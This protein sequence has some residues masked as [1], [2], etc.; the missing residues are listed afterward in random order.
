MDSCTV[1]A[2][3]L[4]TSSATDRRDRVGVKLM[5]GVA[6]SCNAHACAKRRY[7]QIA[8]APK[9]AIGPK[10]LRNTVHI[11]NQNSVQSVALR[12]MLHIFY[13]VNLQYCILS[14]N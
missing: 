2:S 1:T 10:G 6:T 5:R 14:S 4:M 11:S 13:L 7:R 12:K 8:R 9:G 3:T